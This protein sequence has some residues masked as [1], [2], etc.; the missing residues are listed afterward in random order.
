METEIVSYNP[1]A[2]SKAA[3]SQAGDEV[4]VGPRS[5]TVLRATAR[6]R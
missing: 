3:A 2:R 4:V 5:V 1:A 6:L